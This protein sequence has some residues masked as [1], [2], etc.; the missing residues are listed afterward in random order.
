MVCSIQQ[1][2]IAD[3]NLETEDPLYEDRAACVRAPMQVN[4]GTENAMIQQDVPAQMNI[5][6]DDAEND[7]L[8]AQRDGAERRRV[9]FS[10]R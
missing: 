4:N 9:S 1:F 5:D 7:T 2:D 8:H 6:M 3:L 10:G